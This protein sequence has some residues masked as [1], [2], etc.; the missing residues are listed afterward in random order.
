M[1]G[2][3][4]AAGVG[5]QSGGSSS[6]IVAATGSGG[7]GG[8]AGG[9]AGG[10][11]GAPVM[12][13]SDAGHSAHAC[14]DL[15]DQGAVP[16]YA[17][18]IT[19]D[20]W[21][22]LDAD[23][24]DL[25]DVLAGTPPQTFYP[26]TVH[27]GS[28]TV[29][30][31][32]IRLRGKSSWV[33]TVTFDVNP[34]MQFVIAFDQV[35]PKGKFHGVSKVHLEMPRDDWTFL[36]DRI[37]NNWL[38]EIGIA[39][40]CANSARVMINGA[41]YGLY[42]AEQSL[43]AAILE[44]FFPN[45][46][47]GDL[48]K[49]G[50]EAQT[51]AASPNW[52]RLAQLRAAT[53]FGAVSA[54]VDVPNTLLEWAAE[55]VIEDADGYYGGSHNYYL[56]DEGAPGYVWLPD[57]TDSALEWVEMFTSLSYKQHPI[58]WWAGRALPDPPGT[59]YLI[60][61]DDP[62]SRAHYADAIA[63]QVGKWNVQEILGWV[64]AWSAQIADA[65]SADPRKWATPDQVTSA[66]GALRDMVKNRPV[67]LQSFVG[68]EHGNAADSTD[69]DGDGVPWC[70]DCNDA[71]ASVRPGVPEVCGNGVDDNCDGR[72]DEG[73]PAAPPVPDGGARD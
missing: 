70:N 55:A 41:Y 49:G 68:C 29:T 22:K 69:Q 11:G 73:C 2:A 21:A 1:C 46:S 13:V 26:I 33:D 34:K 63:A 5:C 64:D 19:N 8:G 6:R 54:L 15:F 12:T 32:A 50:T 25:A 16:T 45:N 18:D 48:F 58:F 53:D 24:H 61:L 14:P 35:D 31:A 62:T 39:A 7:S 27:Y 28:E 60:I 43:D 3:L 51:N 47:G 56:Y 23:F 57:H 10:G 38:R 65:V 36:N 42:V 52:T 4:F 44:E 30:N 37:G 72:I 40:P 71:D 67:Y 59:D 20:N 17:I 66:L 9:S